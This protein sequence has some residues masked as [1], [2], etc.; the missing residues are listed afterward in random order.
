L[1]AGPTAEGCSATSQLW[2]F[3][4]HRLSKPGTST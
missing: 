1:K 2:S 4:S 3:P